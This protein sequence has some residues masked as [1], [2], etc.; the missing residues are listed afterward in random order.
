MAFLILVAERVPWRLAGRNPPIISRPKNSL[1]HFT[2]KMS[3][4]REGS[5]FQRTRR[6]E[7]YSFGGRKRRVHRLPAGHHQLHFR[8]LQRLGIV[9]GEIRSGRRSLAWPAKPSWK[10]DESQ[11]RL[12]LCWDCTHTRPGLFPALAPI[13]RAPF[14]RQS[15]NGWAA[16]DRQI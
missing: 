12:L 16:R 5:L 9:A 6:G 13:D 3:S 14:V 10:D 7:F 15:A 8:L 11:C 1:A 4:S 2:P